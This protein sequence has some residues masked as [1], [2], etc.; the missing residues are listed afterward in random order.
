MFGATVI[1][2]DEEGEEKTYC[3]VGIDEYNGSKG[4]VSWKS[5]VGM[6]LMRKEVGDVAT[7]KTP[8]GNKDLEILSIK[9][10][11]IVGIEIISRI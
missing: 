4:L 11:P 6:A 3:I 8:S 1:I 7:V 5:P 10:K 9:Y 2:E